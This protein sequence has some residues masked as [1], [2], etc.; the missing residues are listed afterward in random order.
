MGVESP[1]FY[2]IKPSPDGSRVIFGGAQSLTAQLADENGLREVQIPGEGFSQWS[3]DGRYVVFV[4]YDALIGGDSDSARDVYRYD[5]ETDRYT[6]ISVGQGGAG[7]GNFDARMEPDFAAR[8]LFTHPLRAM[9]D[10]GRRVFFGT[11]EQ[12]VPQDHNE[13]P[14]VYEWADGS[15]GLISDGAGDGGAELLGSSDDGGTVL[16]KTTTTLLPRDRDGGETD[17]YVA[18]IGGGFPEA[19]SPEGCVGT[20]GKAPRE[21]IATA[22][23]LSA[24]QLSGGIRLRPLDAATRRRIAASGRLVLLTEVPEPGRLSARASAPVGRRSRTVASAVVEAAEPGPLRLSMQLSKG[25]R[26]RLAAGHDL[27]LRLVL[28]LS[29]LP[30]PRRLSFVLESSR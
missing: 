18:R 29:S 27:R 2:P 1:A 24:R 21:G 3:A 8:P 9:S 5:A 4:T 19:A 14:D 22:T 6:E 26:R 10:D 13:V 25:A 11:A 7:N 15:L 23:P 28:R 30:T 12:L 16:F 17:Y 20:C